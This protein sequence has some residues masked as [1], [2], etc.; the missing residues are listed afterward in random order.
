MDI[1]LALFGWYKGNWAWATPW[2]VILLDK[3]IEIS[4][5]K[6]RDFLLDILLRLIWNGTK[7]GYGVVR[8]VIS[9]RPKNSG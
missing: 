8:S 1:L 9:Y 5:L 7:S 4:P 3:A 2:L 6:Q